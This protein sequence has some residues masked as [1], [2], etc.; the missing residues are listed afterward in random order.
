MQILPSEH[1]APTRLLQQTQQQKIFNSRND[2]L[3]S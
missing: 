2:T 1:L 3:K